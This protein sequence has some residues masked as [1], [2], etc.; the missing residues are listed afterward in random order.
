MEEENI[1]TIQDVFT[2]EDDIRIEE[3]IEKRLEQERF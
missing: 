2:E 3:A 1:E